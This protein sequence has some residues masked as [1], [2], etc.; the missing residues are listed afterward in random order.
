MII[1]CEGMDF[2]LFNQQQYELVFSKIPHVSFMCHSV[3]MPEMNL[4]IAKVATPFHDLAL[5]G[6]KVTFSN[7]SA[8]ILLDKN[9]TT[10]IEIFNWMRKLSMIDSIKS[11]DMSTCTVIVGPKSFVMTGVFPISIQPI[12][13][14]SNPTDAEPITF[15][16]D[17][18]I[19]KFD[20][21]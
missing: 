17:F 14:R 8:E 12:H 11:D 9:L 16:A 6:E 1:P 5:S 2:S 20:L 19:Q 21:T 18:S 4:G 10:Y 7:L 13:L 15:F 3:T